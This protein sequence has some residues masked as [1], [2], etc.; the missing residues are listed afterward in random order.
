MILN[1][2]NLITTLV[3]IH[4]NMLNIKPYNISICFNYTNQIISSHIFAGDQKYRSKLLKVAFRSL[5][6]TSILLQ[7]QSFAL[8]S[9]AEILLQNKYEI[10]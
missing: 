3:K 5:L 4:I 2:C 6:N 10:Y 1:S 9:M 7:S 8:E